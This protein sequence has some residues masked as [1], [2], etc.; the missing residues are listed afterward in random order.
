MY[1]AMGVSAFKGISA[2][3]VAFV[4]GRGLQGIAQ[5]GGA[6][7]WK[8]VATAFVKAT[9]VV[10]LVRSPKSG[11]LGLA[12]GA[13]AAAKSVSDSVGGEKDPHRIVA[14][15]NEVL[16]TSLSF[17]DAVTLLEE[18]RKADVQDHLLWLGQAAERIAPHMAAILADLTASGM[19]TAA[20]IAG[21]RVVSVPL[22]PPAP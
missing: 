11:A 17:R 15:L 5:K 12:P 8:L 22:L 18:L 21:A 7:T 9:A 10:S 2:S 14:A 4:I 1:E 13:K 19:A 3:D 16:G 20:T 6:R